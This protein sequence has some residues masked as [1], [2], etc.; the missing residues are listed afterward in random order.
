M[1]VFV[2]VRVESVDKKPCCC[3]R[4]SVGV[5]YLSFRAA[6]TPTNM[7][8]SWLRG[9][10]AFPTRTLCKSIGGQG[11]AY[12]VVVDSHI[13]RIVLATEETTVM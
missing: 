9:L 13:Q 3:P 7:P 1:C 8:N 4:G 11:F 10:T 5:F 12:V 2:C 6:H